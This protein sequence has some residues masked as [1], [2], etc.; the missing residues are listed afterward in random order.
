MKSKTG[1][2][3]KYILYRREDGRDSK[4]SRP[5]YAAD[6]DQYTGRQLRQEV[7]E[8]KRNDVVHKL[9]LSPGHNDVD[10]KAYVREV[11]TELGIA[12]GLEL[13][14]GF[15]VH[16]NTDHKHA[17]V[18]LL[19]RDTQDRQVRIDKTDHMRLRAFGDRYL[20]R[21]H[22]IERV[23]DRDMEEFCRTRNLNPM[24][25]KERGELFYD[26]LYKDEKK[27]ND[28][29]RDQMEWEKF[30]NDWKK[31]VEDN[32]GRENRPNLG[33]SRF[34]DLGRMAD[35]GS[36]MHND[37]QREIWQD[38]ATNRPEMKEIAEATL[39]QL[40]KD[41]AELNADLD[42]KTK[43]GDPFQAIDRIADQLA[44]EQKQFQHLMKYGLSPQD[45]HTGI[46][47]TRVDDQDKIQIGDKTYTKYDTSEELLAADAYLREDYSHR[48]EKDQFVKMLTWLGAKERFGEDCYG[49]APRREKQLEREP[50]KEHEQSELGKEREIALKEQ[51]REAEYL[52]DPRYGERTEPDRGLKSLD[53]LIGFGDAKQLDLDRNSPMIGEPERQPE[54]AD[55][56]DDLLGIE[57]DQGKELEQQRE[58]ADIALIIDSPRE[59]D[60]ERD[61]GS[62][63]FDMGIN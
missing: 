32:E 53:D 44:L 4:A 16:E 14:Y 17:H 38:I 22:N 59:P 61:D 40:E 8:L 36:L 47:L 41:R 54:R 31:F 42:R 6:R 46:D 35:L 63:L 9:I 20:E 52:A 55:S 26:R 11:M 37:Q 24:F 29:S 60:D 30:N 57:S 10:T 48:I 62:D 51:E 13:R 23:L 27:K 34:H 50:G 15:V 49:E 43:A 2:H 45:S 19:G 56:L 18:V 3:I 12:K 39:A 21:E 5:M 7:D 28:P 58:M 25:E 33:R 1:A